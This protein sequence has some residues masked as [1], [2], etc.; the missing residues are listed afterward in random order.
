MLDSIRETLTD[1]C[2]AGALE[3]IA[4][5]RSGAVGARYK[6][7][8]ELVTDADRRSDE[9]I[10][11]IFADRLP[12]G[13]SFTLEESGSSGPCGNRW[14]GADPLDGTNH[15]ACGGHFYSIQAHYVEDGVPHIGVVFQPEMYLPLAET[16]RCVGRISY[17]VRGRGAFSRRTEYVE[18][19]FQVGEERILRAVTQPATKTFVSCVP[20]STKMTAEEKARALRVIE[21]GLI[22]VTTGLGGAGANV[23]MTIFGGQQVYANFGAGEDLDLIPPQVIAEEAGMTVWGLDRCAPLWTVKKQPFVVAATADTA[24][25]VLDAAGCGGPARG[26]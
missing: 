24:G 13:V 12:L 7:A 1:A 10:R 2:L 11:R 21:S 6:D 9:V 22:S 25:A 3:V 17:A 5:R 20:L 18:P 16:I 15:F 23:M 26:L 4:V 19:G 8:K 14:V